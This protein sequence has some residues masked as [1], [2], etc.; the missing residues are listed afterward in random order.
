MYYFT[1]KDVENL[2]GIKAHTLRIWEQRYGIL[3]PKRK[4]SNHRLYT[5]E[6]L[7]KL[8]RIS[9]L[10][11]QGWKISRIAQLSQEA[12]LNEVLKTDGAQKNDQYYIFRLVEKALDF[13]KEGFLVQLEGVMQVMGFEACIV[14]VCYPL[15]QRIGNMWMTDRM[16]PAQEH[17]CSYIIQHKIIAETDK[18]PPPCQKAPEILLFSP[19][20]EYHDLALHFINYLLR[21][22]GWT[23]LFLG[24]NVKTELL[25]P[26][27]AAESLTHLFLHI[28]VNFTGFGL[29]DYFEDFCKTFFNKKIVASGAAVF[30]VQRT[31]TNLMLLKSDKEIH[32]FIQKRP[33]IS[34]SHNS[35]HLP[36]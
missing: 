4:G 3:T 35:L 28:T 19:H 25:K 26:F 8:L 34:T 7:K 33:V 6:D 11:H 32:Y 2:C 15:L 31:F 16:I 12:L 22:N 36:A 30:S 9:V 10:Y 14:Q 13:D 18:L 29:D 1:I 24:T 21:K 17:F 20:G 23:T 27:A 5:N